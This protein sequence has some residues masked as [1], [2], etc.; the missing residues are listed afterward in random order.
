MISPR[1]IFA[2]SSDNARGIAWMF[3]AGLIFVIVTGSVG[4][5]SS[6]IHPIQLGFLRY[7]IAFIFLAS[8]FGE[9]FAATVIALIVTACI[10]RVDFCKLLA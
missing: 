3:L 1:A 8:V 9:E 6:T 2:A 7:A 5:L 10:S 4:H